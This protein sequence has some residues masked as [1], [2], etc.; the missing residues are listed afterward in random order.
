MTLCKN[1]AKHL[2]VET[3]DGKNMT[4]RNKSWS[5]KLWNLTLKMVAEPCDNIE[6]L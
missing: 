6:N 3:V 4:I 1:R 5:K 2:S